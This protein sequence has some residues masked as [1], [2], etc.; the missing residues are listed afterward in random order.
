[1]K[2]AADLNPRFVNFCKAFGI[3]PVA[4]AASKTIEV[5][6]K[7]VSQRWNAAFVAWVPAMLKAWTGSTGGVWRTPAERGPMTEAQN[8]AFDAW[9]EVAC[10]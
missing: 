6:F 3:D 10:A 8:E 2:T 9:L 5:E 7:G 1:M 4:T